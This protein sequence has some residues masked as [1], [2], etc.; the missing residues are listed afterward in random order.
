MIVHFRGCTPN[1]PEKPKGESPQLTQDFD[2]GKGEILRQCVDC[3][4][5][6]FIQKE[7]K[8]DGQI[9][10]TGNSADTVDR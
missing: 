8:N 5:F 6:E 3:G 7:T 10:T 9:T 1:Y 2:M 4:A